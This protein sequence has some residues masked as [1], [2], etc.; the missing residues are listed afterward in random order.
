MAIAKLSW[1]GKVKLYF[2]VVKSYVVDHP[3]LKYVGAFVLG[4]IV[5][6]VL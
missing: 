3:Y 5:G 1:V 4:L 2:L 6:L